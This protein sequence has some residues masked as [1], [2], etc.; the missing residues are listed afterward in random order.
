[1]VPPTIDERVAVLEDQQIAVDETIRNLTAGVVD[2][3]GAVKSL[4][5]AI[6]GPQN[7]PQEGLLVRM[8]EHDRRKASWEKFVWFV[9]AA[10]ATTGF[11]WLLRLSYIVQSSKLP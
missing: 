8:A 4:T 5:E 11:A 2:L 6:Q 1:M 7:R 3:T 10:I 9:L